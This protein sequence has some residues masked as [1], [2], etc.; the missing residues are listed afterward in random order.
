MLASPL[1]TQLTGVG[2]S[3]SR[4]RVTSVFLGKIYSFHGARSAYHGATSFDEIRDEYLHWPSFS[5]ITE[6]IEKLRTQGTQWWITERPAIV[7]QT[8][9]TEYSIIDTSA[10][11]T[12]KE[13]TYVGAVSR[14]AADIVFS[15]RPTNDHDLKVFSSQLNTLT[16]PTLPF[17]KWHSVGGTR[18]KPIDWSLSDW[19]VDLSHVLS[20]INRVA[21][22]LQDNRR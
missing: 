18:A 13:A 21:Q 19:K 20:I 7:I 15:I 12:F 6:T 10:A 9:I 3:I 17:N 14:R 8:D 22:Y 1:K 16:I 11:G 4:D 5:A 2:A